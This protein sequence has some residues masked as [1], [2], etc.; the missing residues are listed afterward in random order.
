MSSTNCLF[1][2]VSDPSIV[3]ARDI[4]GVSLTPGCAAT[5]Q[6]YLHVIPWIPCR[7]PRRLALQGSVFREWITSEGDVDQP[8]DDFMSK[9]KAT[10]ANV[11]TSIERSM[12]RAGIEWLHILKVGNARVCTTG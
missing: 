11:W 10:E 8:H 7:N 2:P 9:R 6:G 3:P 5:W 4:R 1:T 12:A